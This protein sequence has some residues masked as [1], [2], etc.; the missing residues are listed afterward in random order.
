[1][2]KKKELK[3]RFPIIIDDKFVKY[4]VLTLELR[5]QDYL[6]INP[7]DMHTGNDFMFQCMLDVQKDKMIQYI[8]NSIKAG[9]LRYNIKIIEEKPI[10]EGF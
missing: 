9:T 10:Y 8:A 1:M 6:D 7:M 2:K 5:I 3:K 4:H